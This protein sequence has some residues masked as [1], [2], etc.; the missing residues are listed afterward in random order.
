MTET[1]DMVKLVENNPLNKIN[2]NDNSVIINKI[3]EKFPAYEQQLF[4]ANFYCYLN[5]NVNKDFIVDLDNVWKWIGFERKGKA[6]ELLVN[7]FKENEDFVIK[8]LA[9]PNGEASLQHG[10]QNK[11]TILLT[12]KCFKKLC[13]KTKTKKSDEI[14]E[15]YISLEEL[16]NETVYEQSEQ[17]RNQLSLKDDKLKQKEQNIL[18][19]FDRKPV[20]YVGI[21]ENNVVKFGYSDDIKTRIIDHKNDISKDFTIDLIYESVYNREI[22][23]R[24][25]KHYILSTKII[26]KNYGQKNKIQT[27]LIQLNDNFT[28]KELDIIILEIKRQIE[29]D[30]FSELNKEILELSKENSDLKLQLQQKKHELNEYDD[31]KFLELSKENLELKLENENLKKKINEM[32]SNEKCAYN[33]DLTSNCML[34][35]GKKLVN[36]RKNVCYNF[37]VDFIAKNIIMNNCKTNITIKLTMNDILEKYKKYRISNRFEDAIYDD[38]NEKNIITKAFNEVDGIKNCFIDQLNSRVFYVDIISKWI[39]E[40]VN[41]TP[42]LLGIFRNSCNIIGSYCDISNKEINDFSKK[43]YSFLIEIILNEKI[44]SG[45][46]ILIDSCVKEKLNKFMLQF[47]KKII[48]MNRVREVLLEIPGICRR[49]MRMDDKRYNILAVDVELSTDWILEVLEID[50]SYVDKLKN[51]KTRNY[52][53]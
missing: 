29:S 41:V 37:L 24:I 44:Q 6:K 47:E 3:K 39:C 32:Q 20:L 21:T 22:E 33:I 18:N 26:T 10:G 8:E 23:R 51:I 43:V 45:E 17:L 15:Y 16:I 53:K 7:N 31:I 28:I 11:E 30:E 40:N 52:N 12:I 1:I 25:K 13:M 9:S 34:N 36:L 50:K 2:S 5:Y 14:H 46:I 38:D 49:S 35:L 4:V 19:N 27:E 42:K 48:N